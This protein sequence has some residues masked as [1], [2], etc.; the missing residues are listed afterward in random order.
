V[1][2]PR[3]GAGSLGRNGSTSGGGLGDALKTAGDQISSGISKLTG[4]STDG[5]K[6]DKSS[7]D[8]TKAGNSTDSRNITNSTNSGHKAGE[9]GGGRHRAK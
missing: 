4:G 1:T 9:S 8:E 7:S 2:T 5:G 3:G 6:D